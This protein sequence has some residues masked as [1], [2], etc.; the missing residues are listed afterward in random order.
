MI[1]LYH[2]ACDKINTDVDF[3][4]NEKIIS[5]HRNILCCRSTYF[6]SLLLS[7]FIEKTQK[8]PIEL[9]DIDYRTFVE[10]LYFIYTGAYRQSIEFDIAVNLMIYSNKINLLPAKDAAIERISRHLRLNHDHILTIYE[11]TKKMSPTY[12]LLLDY[13]YDL[14]AE[15]LNDICKH[16]DFIKLEKES[17]VDIMCQG[18]ERRDIREQN[19]LKQL[20]L[21]NENARNNDAEEE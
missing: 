9:T 14:C 13:V 15:Y 10:F 3:I 6:R 8:K 2:Q 4:F 11:L 18:A 19:K 20:T 7:D 17:M 21:L 16:S 1:K 12:D 5:A